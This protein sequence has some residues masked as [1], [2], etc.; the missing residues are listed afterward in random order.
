MHAHTD[1]NGQGRTDGQARENDGGGPTCFFV[2][3]DNALLFIFLMLMAPSFLYQI[4]MSRGLLLLGAYITLVLFVRLVSVRVG[5][6]CCVYVLMI[7][8]VKVVVVYCC[9]SGE[10]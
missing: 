3:S 2:Y 7:A 4:Y 8:L 1:G 10:G 6:W 9:C 5:G